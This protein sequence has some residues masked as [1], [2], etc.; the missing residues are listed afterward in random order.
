MCDCLP[1]EKSDFPAAP[2]LCMCAFNTLSD[3]PVFRTRID[4]KTCQWH[5]SYQRRDGFFNAADGPLGA[6]KSM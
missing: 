4:P 5:F 2:L 1:K 6:L 3:I